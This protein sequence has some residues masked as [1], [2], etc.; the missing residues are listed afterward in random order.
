MELRQLMDHEHAIIIWCGC[1]VLGDWNDR[2]WTRTR[3]DHWHL[4]R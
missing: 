3:N 2:T 4:Q 1:V